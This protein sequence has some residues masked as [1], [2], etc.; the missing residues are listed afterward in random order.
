[1][2]APPSLQD[3]GLISLNQNSPYLS[4]ITVVL[5]MKSILAKA[6]YR[7]F[8]QLSN[9]ESSQRIPFILGS[10]V[11]KGDDPTCACEEGLFGIQIVMPFGM[12]EMNSMI[13]AFR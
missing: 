5:F 10:C 7:V 9:F 2:L 6:G 11:S 13:T 1:M 3:L 12:V 8:E 4:I